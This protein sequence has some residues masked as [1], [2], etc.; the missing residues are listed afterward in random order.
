MVQN[1]ASS[2]KTNYI[3]IY[4]EILI[5]EGHQNCRIR[6]KVTVILLDGWI[7][8]TGG[9]ASEGSAPRQVT[10]VGS[11]PFLMELHHKAK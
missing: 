11:K 5:L 1:G 4:S 6:S 2:Q 8:P 7:L 3:D 10:P 9:V